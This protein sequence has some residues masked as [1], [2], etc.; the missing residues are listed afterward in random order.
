[1]TDQRQKNEINHSSVEGDSPRNP[2]NKWAKSKNIIEQELG[3]YQDSNENP[4]GYPEGHSMPALFGWITQEYQ[5]EIAKDL[6][7][8]GQK[9]DSKK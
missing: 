3:S 5:A 4:K 9:D 8:M 1:M 7:D 6:V 2:A